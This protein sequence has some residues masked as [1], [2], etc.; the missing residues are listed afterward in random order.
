LTFLI[1]KM[2][3]CVPFTARNYTPVPV[4]KTIPVFVTPESHRHVCVQIAL[5]FALAVARIARID[6]PNHWP[7]LF[8]DVLQQLQGNSL[9]AARRVYL[10]LHHILKEL[11]S[12]RLAADQAIFAGVC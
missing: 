1:K 9:L 11:A 4:L 2:R 10:V 7:S 6:Y 12:K 3:G 8:E 5:Q